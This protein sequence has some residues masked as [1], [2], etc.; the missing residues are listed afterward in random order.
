MS[1]ALNALLLSQIAY[2]SP[3]QTVLQTGTDVYTEDVLDAARNASTL[4]N[5][6]SCQAL[7]LPLKRL[8]VLGDKAFVSSMVKICKARKV[9]GSRMF[10]ILLH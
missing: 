8:A 4:K 10:T 9:R 7:L 1:F 5:C 6:A 3:Q 2:G